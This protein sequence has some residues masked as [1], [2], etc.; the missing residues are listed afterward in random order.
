MGRQT[1]EDQWS[2]R[3]VGCC[4][5]RETIEDKLTFSLFLI[6]PQVVPNTEEDYSR[7]LLGL[8]GREV[9]KIIYPKVVIFRNDFF[10][11]SNCSCF[12]LKDCFLA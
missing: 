5:H 8:S 2:G 11:K 7:P 3:G 9:G 10:Q 4:R 12:F 6:Y 1:A